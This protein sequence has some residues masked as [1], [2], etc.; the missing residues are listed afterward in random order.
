MVGGFPFATNSPPGVPLVPKLM[1]SPRR[2]VDESSNFSFPLFRTRNPLLVEVFVK[3]DPVA[4]TSSELSSVSVAPPC[5]CTTLK[6]V[7]FPANAL[8]VLVNRTIESPSENVP[9]TLSKMASMF[10]VFAGLLLVDTDSVE[11]VPDV[12]I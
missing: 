8:L 1:L 12:P 10:T 9:L 2:R 4:V 11:L 5:T 7:A 6:L 3:S